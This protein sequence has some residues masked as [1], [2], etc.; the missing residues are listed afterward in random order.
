MHRLIRKR[1]RQPSPPVKFRQYSS[2]AETITLAELKEHVAYL[3]SDKLEGRFSGTAGAQLL[4]PISLS[5]LKSLNFMASQMGIN[6]TFKTFR[7]K[8]GR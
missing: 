2:Y 6:P 3:A 7:C 1:M 5:T 8:K 4:L